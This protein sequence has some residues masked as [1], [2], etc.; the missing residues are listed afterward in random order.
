[1]AYTEV[2][3]KGRKRYYYRTVSVRE[4]G[5]V[6]KKRRYLGE[7]LGKEELVRAEKKA[8]RELGVLDSLLLP[9]ELAFLDRVR[10][11]HAKEP[12]ATYRNRYEAFVTRFTH[13]S[14]AIE[15]N[16]LTLQETSGLLFDNLSPSG[17]GMREINEI[18][19]HRKA[20]DHMLAHDGDITTDF[21]FAL[22]ELVMKDT[23]S[24]KFEQQI[25]QYRTVQVYIRGLDWRP[26][27]PKDVPGDMSVLLAWYSRNK[28]RLHPLVVAVYFHVGFEV[29]HPFIDGNGRVGRLLMNFILHRNGYPMVNIPNKDKLRYYEALGKAQTGGDLRPFL[30]FVM[31]LYKEGG[32]RV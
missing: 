29:I 9:G 4:G 14:T 23:L 11:E 5:R 8:D 27:A 17:K 30:E 21:I 10:E 28:E 6:T 1:M 26:A 31:E 22:H 12:K 3:K 25:G 7:G 18:L 20:F 19:G 2:K 15:G 32:A 24:P 16:T 13:D